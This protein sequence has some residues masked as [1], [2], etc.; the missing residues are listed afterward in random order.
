MWADEPTLFDYALFLRG[1]TGDV[2]IFTNGGTPRGEAAA[3]LQRAGIAVETTPIARVVANGDHCLE[4]IEL[5][6]GRRVPIESLWLRPAQR[7]RA[8]A[9]RLGLAVDDDGAILRDEHGETPTPGIFAAGDLGAGATQQV[10]Q[11]AADG[12]RVAMTINHQLI[13]DD[14]TPAP[15]APGR[16]AP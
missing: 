8:L 12:A 15:A 5:A 4:A 6:D 7:Q 13:V 16:A 3:K 11:A 9:A 1:W 14:G 10:L 2:T